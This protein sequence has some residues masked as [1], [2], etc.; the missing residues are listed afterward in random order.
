ME[1]PKLVNLKLSLLPDENPDLSWI[2]EYSD[3]WKEGA[4]DRKEQGDWERLQLRYFI[5]SGIR[6]NTPEQDL[7][8]YHRMETYGRLWEMV[9][10]VAKATVAVTFPSGD[11]K[12]TYFRASLWGIESDSDPSYLQE[13]K[14]EVLEELRLELESYGVDLSNWEELKQQAFDNLD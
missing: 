1:T 3:T 2:G 10:I 5:P 11:E 7:E 12:E 14:A 8:D 4:V 13:V 6:G 9:G